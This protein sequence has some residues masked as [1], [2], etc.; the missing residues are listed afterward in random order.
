MSEAKFCAATVPVTLAV[1]VRLPNDTAKV[2][3]V[4]RGPPAVLDAGR[5]FRYTAAPPASRITTMTVPHSPIRRRF[6]GSLGGTAAGRGAGD[7]GAIVTPPPGDGAVL[8]VAIFTL[9]GR[10]AHSQS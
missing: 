3:T 10:E 1:A 2:G 6:S 5:F 8:G 7:T 9:P 4:T